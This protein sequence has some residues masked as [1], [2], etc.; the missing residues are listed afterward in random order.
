MREELADHWQRVYADRDIG[1]LSWTELA[2]A[3]SVQ[4][5]REAALPLDAAVV[6]V[7]GGASP[8]AAALVGAGFSDI[9]VAD[10][11]AQ[12]LEQAR[13]AS[14]EAG[15]V[16]EWIV[17]DVRDHDFGRRF[18]LWHDRAV[19]HFMVD[20]PDRNAYLAVLR[21]SLQA[22]GHLIPATFGPQGPTECSGLP[23]C[24][25]DAEALS[26]ALGGDFELVSALLVDHQTP[27]GKPQQFLYAHFRRRG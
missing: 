1:T 27:S 21:R 17:A 5:I 22:G 11:S 3:N 15:A 12:A 8:L 26:G 24:R 16:V 14:G 23:V 9:T 7:G 10:L 20:P 19:F 4:L 25:Y 2:P 13:A 18:A 6:E